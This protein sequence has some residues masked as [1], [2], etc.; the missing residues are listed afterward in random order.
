[1]TGT[2]IVG[3]GMSS[4][5]LLRARTF[6]SRAEWL[7]A[8]RSRL[9][10]SEIAGV[11]GASPWASPWSIW[12]EKVG[13]A[14][15][16]D[17]ADAEGPMRFGRDLE[18]IINRW[19]TY[20][21]GLHVAGEQALVDHR[22]YPWH[23]ATVDGLV[24]DGPMRLEAPL[25]VL[26]TKY[27]ADPPWSEI[28]EHYRLQVQWQ[29]HVTDLE[30]AWIACMHLP[31]GRPRFEVYELDRDPAEISRMVDAAEAFWDHVVAGTPP[32]PDA[33]PATTAALAGAWQTTTNVPTVDLDEHRALVTEISELRAAKRQILADLAADENRLKALL[34][35]RTEG[36]IEGQVVASWRPQDRTDVDLERLRADHGDAYDRKSTIRVLRLHKPRAP[37]RKAP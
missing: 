21:T 13:L 18:P 12:A 32:P 10:A 31:F 33:N 17:D 20:R 14:P 27:T 22:S 37:R 2:K 4:G 9:G 15:A 23:S 30:H 25:G 7:E 26:E 35:D 16:W 36:C 24:Y 34:Q 8:R 19:F 3:A 29:L 11:M 1:M 6:A 5:A 28:P